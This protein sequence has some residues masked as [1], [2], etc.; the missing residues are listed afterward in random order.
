MAIITTAEAAAAN[1]Y[2]ASAMCLNTD[3]GGVGKYLIRFLLDPHSILS[4]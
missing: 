4:S 2:L 1:I 3:I